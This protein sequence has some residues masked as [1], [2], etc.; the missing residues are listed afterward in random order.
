MAASIISKLYKYPTNPINGIP[1]LPR[2]TTEE[3]FF[4]EF[5]FLNLIIA[6]R[7]KAIRKEANKMEI[8]TGLI[9]IN[10]L[11]VALISGVYEIFNMDVGSELKTQV[12]VD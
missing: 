5:F 9:D 3:N 12:A 4:A 6:A 10:M 8:P 11:A 7:C 1:I 2:I